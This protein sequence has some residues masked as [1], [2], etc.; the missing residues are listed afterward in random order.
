MY[1]PA[2][3]DLDPAPADAQRAGRTPRDKSLRMLAAK[4]GRC[5]QPA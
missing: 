1:A 3:V 4:I 5:R 2:L